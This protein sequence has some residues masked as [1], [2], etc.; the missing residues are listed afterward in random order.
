M[1]KVL[2]AVLGVLVLEAAAVLLVLWSGA[3]DIGTSNQDNRLVNWM[4]DTGMTRSVKRHAQGIKPPPL[5]DPQ[6]V[7]T[8]FQLYDEM[9]VVCH[10]GPGQSR[11]EIAKGIW[12]EAPSL[13]M[14][15]SD[16]NAAELFWITKN[17]I[18]FTAMPAW[19]PTHEEDKI[20][21]M[22][23]FLKKLPDLSPED[24]QAMKS[25][26]RPAEQQGGQE[27]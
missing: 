11:G 4:L 1:K 14:A 24:Y 19:G 2:L 9:C 3:Y 25:K 18:K 13:T 21:A 17:G 20:W 16:W 26:A 7:A 22:V 6:M 27:P 15:A 10:G 12:P 8:G 23:A 5:S